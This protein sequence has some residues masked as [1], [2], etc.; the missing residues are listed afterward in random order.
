M[1]LDA[2]RHR[3]VV[4]RDRQQRRVS[5]LD[6]QRQ[7]LPRTEDFLVDAERNDRE[8]VERV[9][10]DAALF[11]A[12]ADDAEMHALNLNDLV[13]RVDFAKQA[14][15]DIGPEQRHRPVALDLNRAHHPAALGVE[16]GE[17]Q[18]V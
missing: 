8:R 7:R 11:R 4:H 3:R 14:I 10:E 15:G 13:D 17:V 16:R 2:Q 9:P 18:V 1:T 5:R 12:D 6:E